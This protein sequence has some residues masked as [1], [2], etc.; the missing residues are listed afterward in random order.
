M[1]KRKEPDYQYIVD[2]CNLIINHCD[3]SYD[4]DLKR[5]QIYNLVQKL[6]DEVK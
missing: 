4:S 3:P 6:E 2:I 5:C 1:S